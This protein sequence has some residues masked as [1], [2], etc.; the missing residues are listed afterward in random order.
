MDPLF[1]AIASRYTHIEAPNG[2]LIQF[3][4]QDDFSD[5]QI[6]HARRVL[7]SFLTDITNY[8]NHLKIY[9]KY[10]LKNP[11]N[12]TNGSHFYRLI[13][14]LRLG[15]LQKLKFIYYV[16]LDHIKLNQINILNKLF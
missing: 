13:L 2:D 14:I 1:S 11:I 6:L 7:E 4:I 5:N 16:G 15:L 12:N 3:L 8:D 10:G 9:K